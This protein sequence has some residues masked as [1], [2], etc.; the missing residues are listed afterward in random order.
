[1][2]LVEDDRPLLID[3]HFEER[4][5][6][7]YS[8]ELIASE[9]LIAWS[10]EKIAHYLKDPEISSIQKWHNA[11]FEEDFYL[12][13]TPRFQLK[14]MHPLIGYGLVACEQ[15]PPYTY[16]G[17]YAGMLRSR[18]S[19]PNNNYIFGYEIAGYKTPYVV[20]AYRTGNHTRFFNHSERPNL[21]ARWLI[22]GGLSRVI[23][24]TNSWV[25]A[26]KELTYDYGPDYWKKRATPL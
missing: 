24:Y 12:G 4:F 20:D 14:Y 13:V 9:E 11:L 17:Q 23:F 22:I 6:F 2:P 10:E 7:R 18:K 3:A 26:G 21:H 16:M 19:E 8:D 5:G 1:M 25:E 15:I